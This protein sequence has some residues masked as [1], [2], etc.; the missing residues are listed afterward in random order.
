MK[1]CGVSIPRHVVVRTSKEAL[2]A[3]RSPELGGGAVSDVVVKAQVLT[4]GR[5]HG[6]FD[7]GF[8]SGIHVARNEE[9]VAYLAA[10]MLGNRLITEQTTMKGKPVHELLLV[11]RL[12]LKREAYFS[13]LMDSVTAS[14]ML[15]GSPAGGVTIE[16]IAAKTPEL[17]LTERL[18]TEA[19]VTDEI[20]TKFARHMGFEGEATAKC[21]SLI[22]KLYGL[23]L[24]T[25]ATLVEI[26]PLVQAVEGGVFVCGGKLTFDDNVSVLFSVP[27]IFTVY[28][29]RRCFDNLRFIRFVTIDKKMRLKRKQRYMV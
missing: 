13:I 14:L 9:E 16:E 18:D 26:N 11:E 15:V 25:D 10:K 27:E 7:T 28:F 24:K 29:C 3:F 4:S 21:A 22:M 6:I 1:R 17:I 8:R 23:F 12:Y 5:S 19:G 2:E 20:A